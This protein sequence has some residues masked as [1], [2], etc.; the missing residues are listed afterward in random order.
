MPAGSQEPVLSIQEPAHRIEKPVPAI[1]IS[2]LAFQEPLFKVV[3]R[4]IRQRWLLIL[5]ISAAALIPCFW[6]K[7]IEAG[8]L[9]SHVYNAWLAELVQRGELSGLRIVPQ[10]NNVAFDL[11]LSAFR[12]IVNWMWAERLAV[13][14]CVLIFFWGVFAFIAAAT[15]RAPLLLD[16]KSTRLNSSHLGISYAV[17][18]LKQ[19]QLVRI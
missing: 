11:L 14:L 4:F 2:A 18:C 7:H 8:D 16:R 3:G 13:S 15:R 6:H 9:G 17:F 19:K 5:G 10:W 1:Q 12:K